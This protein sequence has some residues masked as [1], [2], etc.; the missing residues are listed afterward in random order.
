[1]S[2]DPDDRERRNRLV[3]RVVIVILGL[4][5]AAYIIVT[6]WGG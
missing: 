5:L 6:F 3:G 1:M 2:D 4:L